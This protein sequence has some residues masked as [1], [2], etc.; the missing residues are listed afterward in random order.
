M[1]Y[2][3]AYQNWKILTDKQTHLMYTHALALPIWDFVLLYTIIY[4]FC[5]KKKLLIKN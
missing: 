4:I 2:I 3:H 5:R 1:I